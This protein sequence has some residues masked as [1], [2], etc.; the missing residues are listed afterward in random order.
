MELH[1]PH[2]DQAFRDSLVRVNVER[3]QADGLAR[4]VVGEVVDPMGYGQA[5]CGQAPGP[6]DGRSQR[7]RMLAG[8]PHLAD[9]PQLAADNLRALTLTRAFNASDPADAQARLAP[10]PFG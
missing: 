2:F 3:S 6:P 10:M 8:E 7:D 9:D 4:L 5:M 1:P